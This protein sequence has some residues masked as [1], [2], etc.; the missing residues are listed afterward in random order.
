VVLIDSRVARPEER[1]APDD[2]AGALAGFALDLGLPLDRLSA[3][4]T[5]PAFEPGPDPEVYL[6]EL[7]AALQVAHLLP[8]DLGREP[9]RRLFDAFRQ[10]GRALRTYRPAPYSG[11]VTLLRAAEPLPGDEVLDATFGWAPIVQGGLDVRAVPGGHYTVVR[12]PY[13]EALAEVIEGVLGGG[14]GGADG[15]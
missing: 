2:L 10:H 7:F 4:A 6:D 1:D 12:P 5:L 9:L 13:V 3:D 8:P 14:E 11:A 15:E